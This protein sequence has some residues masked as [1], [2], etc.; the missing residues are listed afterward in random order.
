VWQGSGAL[1]LN[2]ITAENLLMIG[3]NGDRVIH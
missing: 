1:H 3:S 2:H